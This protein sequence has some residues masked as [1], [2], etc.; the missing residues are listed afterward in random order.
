MKGPN[1]LG[2]GSVIVLRRPA[3]AA[4]DTSRF[5]PVILAVTS[6]K[7]YD[8]ALRPLD[9][10]N[11]T[12]EPLSSCGLCLRLIGDWGASDESKQTKSDG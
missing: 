8:P 3:D 2:V 4:S 10:S 9:L 5:L 12:S 11:T 6:V 1:A 7:N